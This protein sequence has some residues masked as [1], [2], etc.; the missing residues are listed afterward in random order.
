MSELIADTLCLQIQVT[1]LFKIP[2]NIIKVT[3]LLQVPRGENCK[4]LEVFVTYYDK[5]YWTKLNTIPQG[6]HDNP[7]QNAF[8]HDNQTGGHILSQCPV[9]K[10]KIY[11]YHVI[12][13]QPVL[14]WSSCPK[15]TPV[16]EFCYLI[17]NLLQD[18][19]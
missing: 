15:Q 4:N 16:G 8:L 12:K 9:Y 5:M 6:D 7:I 13:L 18:N 14:Q 19:N 2:T 1:L 17:I 11:Q 10:H 3:S